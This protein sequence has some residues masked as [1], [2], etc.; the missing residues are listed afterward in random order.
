MVEIR[1]R[2]RHPAA[3]VGRTPAH[4]REFEVTFALRCSTPHHPSQHTRL[5]I[6][7]LN[8]N[9]DGCCDATVLKIKALGQSL[10]QTFLPQPAR[11]RSLN[12]LSRRWHRRDCLPGTITAFKPKRC[13]AGRRRDVCKHAALLREFWS[14]FPVLPQAVGRLP[15]HDLAWKTQTRLSRSGRFALAQRLN[16]FGA[17][18]LMRQ[19]ASS[20]HSSRCLSRIPCDTLQVLQTCG[21][22]RIASLSVGE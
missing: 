18:R 15:T 11:Y 9:V 14:E 10:P 2:V 12:P 5:L 7:N 21:W 20:S 1:R 19:R 4:G 13:V 22:P 8:N 3:L 6:A 16:H 17:H